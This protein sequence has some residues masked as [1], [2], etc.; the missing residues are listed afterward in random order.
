[1]NILK[2]W[3]LTLF[4]FLFGATISFAETRT[5]KEDKWFMPKPSATWQIQLQGS[6]NTNYDNAEMY[7]ID[8]YDSSEALIK[9]LQARGKNVICYFSAGS[10]E[11]WRS[12]ADQFNASD[13]GNALDGWE[14]ERWLDI[15]SDNV[16]EIMKRRLDLAE[17]KGCGGVDP[18]NMD[19]YLN[20]SGLPINAQDQL[21]YNRFIANEAHER[22][23]SVGLKNDLDQIEALVDYFD[24]AVNEQCFQYDECDLLAPF[25]DQGKAVFNIEYDQKYTTGSNAENNRNQLC[26][27]AQT[28]KLSTLVMPLLLD[29]AFR[30]SCL[31]ENDSPLGEQQ[32]GTNSGETT[33]KDN[34]SDDE[35]TSAGGTLTL[36]WFVFV[37]LF[38]GIYR[39]FFARRY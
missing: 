7:D 17:L 10:Y 24:F 34:I 37:W 32:D 23:L 6:V 22:G 2:S 39:K 16:R 38:S 21:N 19:G 28:R 11:D 33:E 4:L 25:I 12:D 30:L 13:L 26:S 3:L 31:E 9:Q 20:E 15:R 35:N 18:D 29:D 5:S 36:E 14:G 1:M 8:L 27:N